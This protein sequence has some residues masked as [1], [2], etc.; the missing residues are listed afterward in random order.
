M[1][2]SLWPLACRRD[3][4]SQTGEDGV[5][6]A[7][8]E[9]LPESDRWC[10]EFGA[11]DGIYANNTRRLITEEGYNA[12]LIEGDEKRVADLRRNYATNPKVLPIHRFVT[13]SG[14][15]R[16]DAILAQTPIPKN[17]DFLSIDIDGNDYYIWESL[18]DYRPKLV[19]VEF[20]P[21]IPNEVDFV[22]DNS[23][24]VNHGCS[25][26]ALVRLASTKGYE[27]ACVLPFNAFFIK[28]EYFPLLEIPDNSLNTL[29]TD[30]SNIT[31][32]FSGYDGTIFIRGNKSLSWIGIPLQESRMQHLP[33]WLRR[34][35]G[36]YNY[37]QKQALK[38][39][40]SLLKRLP[41][42]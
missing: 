24:N 35:P 6:Q 9:K 23:P 25:V 28:A 19:V 18:A 42:K 34:Y 32:F 15:N 22:Q 14:S 26:A 33:L 41:A 2:N 39:Y 16:L 38:L 17:F 3:I 4:Y 37:F 10:V 29:R 11:W 36:N 30:K 7:L 20:N 31:Y 27:L 13:T 1:N 21:T 8:L 12:V 40:K 5:V